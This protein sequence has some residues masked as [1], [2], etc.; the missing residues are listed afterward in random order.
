M[1]GVLITM[2]IRLFMPLV[3]VLSFMLLACQQTETKDAQPKLAV[4][5]MARIMRDSE[6]GKAGVKFLESL[7]SGMQEKLNAIQARLE[8]DPKDEAAQKE[9]QGVYM[10][11]QQRMQAE[12]QNVVNLLYDTIQRVL[13]AYREQQGYDIILSAEVAAAF[14][15]KADVTAAVIAEVNKQKIDFKPLPEPAAPEAAP[16][17]AAQPQDKE[18]PKEQPKADAPE[19]GKKK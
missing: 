14:N 5:D 19:N 18:Q 13:N 6:P 16:A 2:R 4:V 3:F 12:Q 15:P 11:S 8:K 1:R 9:L 7:Q 17:P 10:A